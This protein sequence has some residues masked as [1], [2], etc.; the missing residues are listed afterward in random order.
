MFIRYSFRR[1]PAREADM[2]SMIFMEEIRTQS[3]L[4][5]TYSAVLKELTSVTL[6]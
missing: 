1:P 2:L 6:Q 5:V 3:W 4:V